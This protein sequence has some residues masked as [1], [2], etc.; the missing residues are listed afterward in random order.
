MRRIPI[1]ENILG[2]RL[3]FLRTKLVKISKLAFLT[4]EV[5]NGLKSF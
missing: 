2:F 3:D 1:Y 4:P 5:Y